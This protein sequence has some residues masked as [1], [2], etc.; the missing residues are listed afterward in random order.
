MSNQFSHVSSQRVINFRASSA[1]E[2]PIFANAQ[3]TSNQ[4][5]CMLIYF[6][7]YLNADQCQDIL[8]KNN[9]SKGRHILG[10]HH[11]RDALSKRRNVRDF[12][13]GDTLL[14]DTSFWHR[15]T[16]VSIAMQLEDQFFP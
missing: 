12:S 14:G 5:S 11:P 10:L 6:D 7:K 2:K 4:L 3:P 1:N 16:M 15:R 8:V 9:M 13:F